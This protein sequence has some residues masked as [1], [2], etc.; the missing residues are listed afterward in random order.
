MRCIPLLV[1]ANVGDILSG[2]FG[3][4]EQTESQTTPD[5]NQQAMN[6]LRRQ[7]LEQ[8]FQQ[9]PY[10]DFAKAR[11][12]LFSLSGQ[13]TDIMNEATDL[14]NLMSLD[15]YLKLGLDQ[16]S[17]YM[18]QIARPEIMSGLAMQGME[19]SGA[20]S[21]ALAKGAASIGLPFLQSIPQFGTSRAQQAE[22]MFNMSAM[23]QQLRQQDLMRQQGVVT[24]G[25]T[26]IPFS[27]GATTEG[28]TSSLPLWNM[29]GMGGG[30]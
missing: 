12:D 26:G 14:S 6:A 16:G 30:I 1:E 21:E 24:T 9:S 25:L 29:F 28:G 7:Q 4:G 8:L 10:A 5:A 20:L 17:S 27:A 11:P 3:G 18:S 22:S 23:P 15:D 13:S 19:G 2:I